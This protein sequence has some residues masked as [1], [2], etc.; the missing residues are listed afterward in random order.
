M[1][2]PVD[3]SSLDRRES[4]LV[5]EKENRV[6]VEKRHVQNALYHNSDNGGWGG[7][8]VRKPETSVYT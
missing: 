1:N 4:N 2:S 8:V 5:Q 7:G 3:R 6:T